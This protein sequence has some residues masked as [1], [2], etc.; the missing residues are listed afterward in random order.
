MAAFSSLP[1]AA[2][3]AA[4]ARMDAKKKQ[5]ATPSRGAAARRMRAARP[6]NDDRV[7]VLNPTPGG[8]FARQ[9][10]ITRAQAATIMFDSAGA[11]ARIAKARKRR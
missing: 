9:G 2:Q 5:A 11:A 10:T 7:P 8:G 6:G 3:R 4:F 1:R